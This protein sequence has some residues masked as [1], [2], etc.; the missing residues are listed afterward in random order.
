MAT[1]AHGS[2]PQTGGAT[3]ERDKESDSSVTK[4]LPVKELR[5]LT[6]HGAA[7]RCV[8]FSRTYLCC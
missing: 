3:S 8:K 2:A 5:T 1:V 6:G 7:I 4:K